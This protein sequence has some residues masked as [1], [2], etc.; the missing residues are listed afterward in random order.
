MPVARVVRDRDPLAR[1]R[2]LDLLVPL[3]GGKRI[4]NPGFTTRRPQKVHLSPSGQI[5][6]RGSRF[7]VRAP[8]GRGSPSPLDPQLHLSRP[9]QSRGVG[10]VVS[11][12]LTNLQHDD[13]AAHLGH[14]ARRHHV[15]HVG[16]CRAGSPASASAGATR[17]RKTTQKPLQGALPE[18]TA[19]RNPGLANRRSLARKGGAS[20]ENASRFGVRPLE[21]PCKDVQLMLAIP[22]TPEEIRCQRTTNCG[23]WG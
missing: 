5:F 22:T 12:S 18:A 8:G 14:E 23:S 16:R 4:E 2:D 20:G 3:V 19:L 11:R 9:T 10:L 1:N 21:R 7:G 6:T 15:G 17:S 13:L